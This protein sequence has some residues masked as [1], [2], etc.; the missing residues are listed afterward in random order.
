MPSPRWLVTAVVPLLVGAALATS[1]AVATADAVDD[2][3][4]SQLRAAGFSWPPDHDAALT[5]MG[6]LIC[7]DIGWGYT[8]DRISQDIHNTLDSRNVT[9]GDV[10]TM[11]K[12]AHA[13]YCPLQ[14]CWT[15]QC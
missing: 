14:R 11:V 9:I 5:A 6:R 12:I 2:A 1:A 7:D 3:Y 10:N 13:T 8:Y 4:L 15:A